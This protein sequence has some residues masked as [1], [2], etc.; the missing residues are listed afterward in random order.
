[1]HILR[2]VVSNISYST[3]KKNLLNKPALLWLAINWLIL[4][5]VMYDSEVIMYG[6]I[7][8][9]LMSKE[10]I[11]HLCFSTIVKMKLQKATRLAWKRFDLSGL[12]FTMTF[13]GVTFFLVGTLHSRHAAALHLQPSRNDSMGERNLW[14]IE[15][16]GD[17]ASR[18]TC[19]PV[20]SRSTA[21][22]PRQVRIEGLGVL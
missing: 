19:S 4:M 16:I 7:G 10:Q 6:E 13:S 12:R 8:Y 3:D 11:L 20:G 18:R 17:F 22:L 14:S 5:S 1:M 21:S 15:A 2:T 9:Q